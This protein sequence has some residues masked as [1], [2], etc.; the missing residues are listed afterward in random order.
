MILIIDNYDSFTYN[1]VQQV[2]ALGKKTN[3]FANDRITLAEIARK[4]P[5][6]IIISPG[7]G[8]P[9]DAG[10]SSQVIK[11]FYKST[12]IL[13]VCLGHQCIGLNFGAKLAHAS[14]VMHGKTS[15]I[16]HSGEGLFKDVPADLTVARYH[17]LVI[18]DIR[19]PLTVT[20]RSD[21]GTVMAVEHR[22]YPLYG[23]QFHPES[24][25]TPFGETIIRN[26]LQ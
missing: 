7:P 13:G 8:S 21:D 12:P 14:S 9:D 24:F 4:A 22:D 26:F 20:A 18:E 10:V 2:E 3:V 19:E 15:K 6:K 23:V 17:S 1:I 16:R 11:S 5:E 25:L